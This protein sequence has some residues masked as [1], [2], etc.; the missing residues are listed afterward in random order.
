[1]KTGLE[2]QEQDLSQVRDK[3]PLPPELKQRP[4]S[5]SCSR[6]MTRSPTNFFDTQPPVG[7][8]VQPVSGLLRP[9]PMAPTPEQEVARILSFNAPPKRNSVV[10]MPT[11]PQDCNDDQ[12]R[13]RPISPPVYG[14]HDGGIQERPMSPPPL[15]PLSAAGQTGMDSDDNDDL[16]IR[17]SPVLHS[18]SMDTDSSSESQS[19]E[20]LD[21]PSPAPKRGEQQRPAS[22]PA[23]IAHFSTFLGPFG[24]APGTAR[25]AGELDASVNARPLS[26]QLQRSKRLSSRPMSPTFMSGSFKHFLMFQY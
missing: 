22:M 5:P 16:I 21:S 4:L 19:K 17:F 23:E 15:L 25:Q 26:P 10:N 18:E 14:C 6:K 13:F 8:N 20:S 2:D 11:A 9:R 7:F 24:P 1:M 3:P 12:L